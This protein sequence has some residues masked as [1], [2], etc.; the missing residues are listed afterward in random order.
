MEQPTN[1]FVQGVEQI[2]T[3]LN[4]FE[5]IQEY[6]TQEDQV[7]YRQKPKQTST[8]SGAEIWELKSGTL[9][10]NKAV[11]LTAPL[12]VVENVS[13]GFVEETDVLTNLNLSIPSNQLIMIHGPV[14]SGKTALL[15]LL[16]SELQLKSGSVSTCF[17]Q[18]AYCPQIPWITYGTIESNITGC[19]S[20]DKSWYNTVIEACDLQ[21]DFLQLP[22]GDQTNTG[23]CGS[24]LSGGQKKRIVSGTL[25][26]LVGTELLLTQRRSLLPGPYIRGLIRYSWMMF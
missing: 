8:D 7:D 15:R 16:L 20:V 11:A 17:S 19:S 25:P 5:R 4:S 22:L 24:K 6:L 21:A 23:S 26:S 14:G 13:A 2:Q 18:T 1:T 12:A 3:I 9:S 10:E